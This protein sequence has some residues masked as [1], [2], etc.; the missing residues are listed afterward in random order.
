MPT[1]ETEDWA[2]KLLRSARRQLRL[3]EPSSYRAFV[4]LGEIHALELV[5]NGPTLARVVAPLVT[6]AAFCELPLD[7]AACPS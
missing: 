5:L 3:E 6:P 7:D 2:A 1:N 4:L